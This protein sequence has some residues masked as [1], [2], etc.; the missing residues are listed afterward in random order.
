MRTYQLTDKYHQPL[1]LDIVFGDARL[2]IAQGLTLALVR[3]ITL[4]KSKGESENLSQVEHELMYGLA[5]MN[6]K[7][8]CDETKDVLEKHPQ[9]SHELI[10]MLSAR[11][12]LLKFTRNAH[13]SLHALQTKALC[14]V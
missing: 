9:V 12:Q 6:L 11:V 10:E 1:L 5:H 14:G 2:L 4:T 7:G 13:E 8:L 3:S